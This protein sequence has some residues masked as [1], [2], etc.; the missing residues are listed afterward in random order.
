MAVGFPVKDDYATGD[1]LT[2][3]NMN[4]FAGT[5]NTVPDV[6]GGFAAAKNKIINGDFTLNQRNFTTATSDGTYTFDRW[7]VSNT[8]VSCT[9]TPQTFTAGAA[10]VA[11]YESTN[12]MRILTTGQT[13]TTERTILVQRI[14]SVRTFAAQTATISFWAKADSGTPKIAVEIAQNFG[15]GGSA[16]VNTYGSQVTLSTSWARYSATIAIPSI[17]GKTIGTSN[18][19]ALNLWVSAGSD[20]NARTGT[21]G[22]QT[23][24]FDIWGVQVEAGNQMTPFQ[25]ATGT[26]EGELAA[27]QR[28]YYRI[29]PA[30]NSRTFGNGFCNETTKVRGIINFPVTMRTSPTALEQSG[31][32]ADYNVFTSGF[33]STACSSVPLIVSAIQDCGAVE[34]TVASGLTAGTGAFLRTGAS[35]GAAAY[36]GWSAEL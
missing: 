36:L 3:A 17:S 2:A 15:S 10:P 9:Y 22:I 25:T 30:V 29:F 23:N 12:F 14:E 4:D 33:T 24:T 32:A 1:V 8:G 18:F 7:V 19:L 28:Y 21:L 11:G 6:V 20:F 13:A 34:F 27:C 5:L 31:T 35:T 26:I 16:S